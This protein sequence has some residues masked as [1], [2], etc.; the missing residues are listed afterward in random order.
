MRH[1]TRTLLAALTI[2]AA[3]TLAACTGDDGPGPTPTPTVVVTTTPTPTATPTLSEQD[4]NIADAKTTYLAFVTAYDAA[5]QAG[6]VDDNLTAVV[7]DMTSGT[8]REALVSSQQAFAESGL[9][10]TGATVVKALEAIDYQEDTT[11]AGMHGVRLRACLDLSTS[12]TVYADGSSTTPTDQP[13][14]RGP[15]HVYVQ[16]LRQT[17]GWAVHTVEPRPEEHC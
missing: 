10:Q 15:R 12:D 7:L 4:Q 17:G 5:A 6:F 3:A 9:R 14:Y 16:M 1:S 8:A 11:G 13:Q 2:A